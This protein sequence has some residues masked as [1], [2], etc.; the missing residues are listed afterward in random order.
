MQAFRS[1]GKLFTLMS[2]AAMGA[3]DCG[4]IQSLVDRA[5][6]T[7]RDA[8]TPV[9]VNIPGGEYE[10][11]QPIVLDQSHVTLNGNGARVRL[12]DGA[13]CPVFIIGSPHVKWM[14]HPVTGVQDFYTV[15]AAGSEQVKIV[16]KISL[17]GFSVDGN[18]QNQ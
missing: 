14:T 10:C 6:R 17:S 4:L 1:W 2:S 12:A 8:S 15:A 3:D 18:K 5:V 9:V 13:N 16:E 11:K 7:R